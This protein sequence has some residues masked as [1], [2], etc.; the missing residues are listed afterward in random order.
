MVDVTPRLGWTTYIVLVR[1]CPGCVLF[2][3]PW[4]TLAYFSWCVSPCYLDNP[5]EGFFYYCLKVEEDLLLMI[6]MKT[7]TNVKLKVEVKCETKS[8]SQL[9]SVLSKK[10][11]NEKEWMVVFNTYWLMLMY[12][13]HT[14]RKCC[15]LHG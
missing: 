11:S 8:W 6:K 2:Y 7:Q 4:R 10:D 13:Q 5:V 14:F 9:P 1:V 12:N 15:S 3:V